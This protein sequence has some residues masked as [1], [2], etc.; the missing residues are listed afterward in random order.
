MDFRTQIIKGIDALTGA[1]LPLMLAELRAGTFDSE[2]SLLIQATTVAAKYLAPLAP[3]VDL[4]IAGKALVDLARAA[5]VRPVGYG[6]A[7]WNMPDRGQGDG[8]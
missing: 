1:N 7:A 8:A 3:A 4:E 6:D 2:A 5:G